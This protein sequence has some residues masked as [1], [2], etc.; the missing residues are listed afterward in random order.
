MASLRAVAVASGL[1]VAGAQ[2]R[3][4]GAQAAIARSAKAPQP[5][6]VL[7]RHSVW[8]P[9][10]NAPL[11]ILY[12]DGTAI[13]ARDRREPYATEYRTAR[14]S[15]TGRSLLA[16]MSI[17]P[18]AFALD[19]LYDLHPNITDLSSLLLYVWRGDTLTRVAVRA[20]ELQGDT[21]ATAVPAAFKAV[22][23]TMMGFSAPAARPWTPDSLEV[24]MWPY[25]YAPDDPPLQWPPRWPNLTDPAT[26]H[27]ADNV[28]AETW[29]LRLP[30][31]RRDSLEAFLRS[32]REKQAIGISGHKVVARYR[33][34]YPGEARWRPLLDRD[35]R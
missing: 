17:G 8:Y 13:Y 7:L 22:Y 9:A 32:V 18:R 23:A 27:A 31:A 10:V 2:G 20:G 30:I 29:R 35:M 12:D 25:E 26:V 4:V 6:A 19:T 3:S 5:I 15:R 33:L 21:L 11:F 1:L 14:L 34:L 16:E 28:V 24:V